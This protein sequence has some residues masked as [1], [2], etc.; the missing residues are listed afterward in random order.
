MNRI[1]NNPLIG[2]KHPKSTHARP[3]AWGNNNN[4]SNNI[5]INN[6]T[7]LYNITYIFKDII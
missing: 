3:L 7:N 4:T 5:I 6:L 1:Q 2:Q